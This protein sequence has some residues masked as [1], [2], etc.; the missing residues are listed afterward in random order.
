MKH[1][2]N[3]SAHTPYNNVGETHQVGAIED[4]ERG[5]FAFDTVPTNQNIKRGPAE[6]D[7]LARSVFR[8]K[9][10][11]ETTQT[12]DPEIARVHLIR[13]MTEAGQLPP[14]Q[15]EFTNEELTAA[16]EKPIFK[17][18]T[19]YLADLA[20]FDYCFVVVFY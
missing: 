13:L 14:Q 20:F 17:F 12:L 7:E 19:F 9:S 11:I 16:V 2:V 10:Q 3:I 8:N 1:G 15:E 6:Y 4:G 5:F 18:V